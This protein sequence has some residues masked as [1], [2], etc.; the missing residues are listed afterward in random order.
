MRKVDAKLD[1]VINDLGDFK[2]RLASLEFNIA[3][4]DQRIANQNADIVA[5][6]QHLG[7]IARSSGQVGEEENHLKYEPEVT[8]RIG[9]LDGSALR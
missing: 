4:L 8:Q 2:Q 3:S 6:R 5:I 7:R 1:A 9:I